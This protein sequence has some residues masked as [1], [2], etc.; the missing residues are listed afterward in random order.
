MVD[1]E[2]GTDSRVVS[3]PA[4]SGFMWFD[5]SDPMITLSG[6]DQGRPP[7]TL[8]HDIV[9]ARDVRLESSQR[10][11]AA[12]KGAL[13]IHRSWDDR[14]KCRGYIRREGAEFYVLSVTM[15]EQEWQQSLQLLSW[16]YQPRA[17]EIGFD[18]DYEQHFD[19]DDYWDDVRYPCVLFNWY[20]LDWT[21]TATSDLR[22]RHYRG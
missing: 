5:I 19:G 3:G 13:S 8:H 10:S 15:T 21:R 12:L 6:D 9:A 14:W 18:V 4:I 16:G 20:Q 17:L 1:Q 11:L 7:L 2:Q 22:S